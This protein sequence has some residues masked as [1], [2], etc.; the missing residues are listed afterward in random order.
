MKLINIKHSNPGD[1]CKVLHIFA[2]SFSLKFYK[3]DAMSSFILQMRKLLE[4]EKYALSTN[5]EGN[6]TCP[7]VGFSVYGN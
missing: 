6:A 5:T 4:E 1:C 7:N 3:G 2:N